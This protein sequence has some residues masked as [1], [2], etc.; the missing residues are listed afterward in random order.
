MAVYNI[1]AVYLNYYKLMKQAIHLLETL[2]HGGA[3][4]VPYNYAKVLSNLGVSSTFVAMDS[5]AE[6]KRML[7]EQGICIEKQIT[8]SLLDSTDYVFIHSSKN[9]FRLLPYIRKLK[10]RKTRVVYIQHLFYSEVKFRILSILINWLCTDFI[11]ITPIT[12]KIVGKYIKIPVSF[13]VNFYMAKYSRDAYADIRKQVRDELNL[14]QQQTVVMFSAVFRKGKGLEDCLEL[15][16]MLSDNNNIIFLVVGDGPESYLLDEYKGSNIIRI[17]FIN[18][19]ERYLIASDI[20]FFPS[21]YKKEML[22]MALVEAVDTD[23]AI[24]AVKNTITDFVLDG[25]TYSEL[26]DAYKS[27][28]EKCCPS[29]F[30]HYDEAYAKSMLEKLL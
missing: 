15:A 12:E 25:L 17:G 24:L 14:P 5:S 28:V 26:E 21:K 22:P 3:E 9:L 18:D 1:A 11:R 13:I 6:Y 2:K 23:T 4:N 16:G 20:Y 29:G 10:R 8:G 30:T 19:V 7:Q 27:L